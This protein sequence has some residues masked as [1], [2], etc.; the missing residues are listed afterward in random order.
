MTKECARVQSGFRCAC[1]D[2]FRTE[3]VSQPV[4][5]FAQPRPQ[6]RE[7]APR[8]LI[9]ERV[10][11]RIGLDELSRIK[12]TERIGREIPEHAARPVAVLKN[13]HEIGLGRCAQELDARFVPRALQILYA[14]RAGNQ[15][16]LELETHDDMEVIGHF[17]SRRPHRSAAHA[18]DG[19]IERLGIETACIL[20][21]RVAHLWHKITPEGRASTDVILPETCLSLMHAEAR[22]VTEKRLTVLRWVSLIIK[23]VTALVENCEH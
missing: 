11:A 14:E 19:A 7:L 22:R 20:S 3:T 17:V 23:R 9:V 2:L 10:S 16:P 1:N 18:V 15:L 5:V 12:A 8:D 6:R 4:D 21:V 13:A